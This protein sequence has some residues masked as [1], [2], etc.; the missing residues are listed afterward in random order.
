[1]SSSDTSRSR[2]TDAGTS[3][4]LTLPYLTRVHGHG[5]DGRE[6]ARERRRGGREARAAGLRAAAWRVRARVLVLAGL[7]VDDEPPAPVVGARDPRRRHHCVQRRAGA[8]DAVG[9]L[10]ARL[11]QAARER[12]DAGAARQVPAAAG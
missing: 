3:S 8:E 2:G 12:V 1:M 5:V 6:V 4:W 10:L 11:T 7:V 9:V